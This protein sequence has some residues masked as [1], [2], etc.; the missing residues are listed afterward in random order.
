MKHASQH[1]DSGFTLI[2]LVIV[3]A[4][5][6]MVTAWSFPTLQRKVRQGEVDR[7]HKPSKPGV[8]LAQPARHD[9]FQLHLELFQFQYISSPF[10]TA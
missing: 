3:A 10:R 8:Q 4:L 5:I 6:S 2:E 7:T 9:T 1:P